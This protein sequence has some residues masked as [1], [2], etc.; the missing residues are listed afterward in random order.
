MSLGDIDMKLSA[1]LSL[2]G[3][4][5]KETWPELAAVTG[6]P[7]AWAI[8]PLHAGTHTDPVTGATVQ[9]TG[10]YKWNVTPPG[11]KRM[12]DTQAL[13]AELVLAEIDATLS[14]AGFLLVAADLALGVTS[15]I[16]TVS[17]NIAAITAVAANAANINTLAPIAAAISTLAGI[18]VA[19]STAATNADAIVDV[20]TDLNLGASSLILQA[21]DAATAAIAAAATVGLETGNQNVRAALGG[22]AEGKKVRRAVMRYDVHA[23]AVISNRL[24][25]E[26]QNAGRLLWDVIGHSDP[27]G[28]GVVS[29]GSGR[30]PSSGI[31]GS[32]PR[33]LEF[34]LQQGYDPGYRVINRAVSARKSPAM[35]A[36]TGSIPILVTLASGT[37][38]PASGAVALSLVTPGTHGPSEMRGT[39]YDVYEG[40][41][42]TQRCRLINTGTAINTV[43]VPIYTLEQVGGTAPITVNPYTHFILAPDPIDYAQQILFATRNDPLV[44]TSYFMVDAMV[45][46]RRPGA[47]VPFIFGTWNWGDGTEDMLYPGGVPTPSAGLSRVLTENARMQ[48]KYGRRFFDWRACFRGDAPYDG[49]VY[50]SI[51]QFTGIDKNQAANDYV[52]PGDWITN[53]RLPKFWFGP[54]KGGSDLQHTNEDTKFYRMKYFLEI[55]AKPLGV[56]EY[57]A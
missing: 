35:A 55:I 15:K 5:T 32:D 29:A 42:G 36:L 28:S 31:S 30:K 49:T 39:G 6:T 25:T 19:V 40:Y 48:D 44:A 52:T 17:T 7:N 13:A 41:I 47:P 8:V 51:W 18:S 46:A 9:N 3:Y 54:G 27:A 16:G 38:L 11:W 26:M 2:S 57:A 1:A 23:K 21:I 50:P 56:L 22:S 10:V 43:A 33:H 20:A 45:T 24:L 34:L 12:F 53:G 37:T 14:D 4:S